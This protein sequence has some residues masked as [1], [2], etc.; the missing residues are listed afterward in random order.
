MRVGHNLGSEG[1]AV[2]LGPLDQAQQLEL[3]S[4]AAGLTLARFGGRVEF[5]AIINARSGIC[6]EDC[7]FCA[8]S[9]DHDSQVQTYPLLAKDQVIDAA[10]RAREAG[11]ARFSIVTSGKAAKTKDLDS[12]CP[13]IEAVAGLGLSPCASLGCLS[14]PALARLASAGLV[15]YHHNLEAAESYYPQV[16]TTHTYTE[17]LATLKAARSAGLEVCSG[18]IFG[19]GESLAQRWELIA[20]LAELGLDSIAVN[21]LSPIPGTPLADRPRL[22]P[23][24]ALAILAVIRLALPGV[25]IRTCGGRQATLGPLAPLQYLAGA[26]ATMTGDYLTTAGPSPEADAAEVRFIGLSLA[27]AVREEL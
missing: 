27:G 7:V 21:F 20:S 1:A 18:G 6:G 22:D 3:I 24:E 12:I 8:Q 26:N 15:R 19:L 10:R 16:C 4:L 9:A 5:C 11:A 23:W 13:M 14:Q 17:R 25:E 2:L